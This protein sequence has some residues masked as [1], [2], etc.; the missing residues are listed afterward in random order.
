MEHFDGEV[1]WDTG[2]QGNLKVVIV[3]QDFNYVL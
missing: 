2:R 3:R 1:I